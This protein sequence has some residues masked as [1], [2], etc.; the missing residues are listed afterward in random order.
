MF[1][2]HT[3]TRVLTALIVIGIC[4]MCSCERKPA[5][6][7]KVTSQS[8]IQADSLAVTIELD[9]G[10]YAIGEPIKMRLRV[11]NTTSRSLKLFFPT[12]QRYDFIVRKGD[13]TLWQWSE[14]M[15]FAQVTSTLVLEPDT[16]I[17]YEATWNQITRDGKAL[18]LGRYTV[19]GI[20]RTQPEVA[21][22]PRIFG[23]VD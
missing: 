13:E 20:L 5:R 8:P 14:G 9:Q 10:S 16:T 4:W 15:M 19:E 22:E 17:T 3:I 6:G 21:S 1:S 23:I 2:R 11:T 7:K 18:P 12:A